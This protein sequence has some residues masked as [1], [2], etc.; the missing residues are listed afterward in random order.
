VDVADSVTYVNAPLIAEQRGVELGLYT[1]TESPEFQTLVTLRGALVDGRSLTVSGT[2]NPGLHGGLRL[3]EID[4]FELDIDLDGSLL[5]LRYTDR[6]GVVGLIGGTL[7]DLGINI[8]AMQ[9][10]R[11]A[12][13]GEAVMAL[14]LDAPVPT[15]VLD[16]IKDSVGATG[17]KAV[18]LKD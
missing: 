6:P 13:G 11:K 4:G 12:A 17:A 9:V 10:A 15:E 8:A 2:I 3:T 18:T 14:A 5:F 16:R 7:G 1:S